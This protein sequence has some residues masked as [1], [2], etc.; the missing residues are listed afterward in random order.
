MMLMCKHACQLPHIDAKQMKCVAYI[1][2]KR[3]SESLNQKYPQLSIMVDAIRLIVALIA[4]AIFASL[5]GFGGAS[6]I[7]MAGAYLIGG[8]L[9]LGLVWLVA[10]AYAGVGTAVVG[11]DA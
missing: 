7:A 10:S 8:L 1:Q 6:N 9:V 11:A 2:R 4:F 3:A 5:L